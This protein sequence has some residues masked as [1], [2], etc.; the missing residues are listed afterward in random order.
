MMLSYV[1]VVQEAAR[2]YKPLVSLDARESCQGKARP[3]IVGERRSQQTGNQ[4]YMHKHKLAK[5]RR[6]G[7]DVKKKD[8]IH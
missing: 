6:I 5:H 8:I 7:R 1:L 2:C 4:K 3:E